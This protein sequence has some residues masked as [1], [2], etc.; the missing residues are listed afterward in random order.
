MA[1]ALAGTFL[2]SSPVL[3]GDKVLIGP[4]PDWL[5]PAPA[6][7]AQDLSAPGVA[8]PLYDSQT[9]I[10][11]DRVETYLDR[12]L[13]ISSPDML[14]RGGNLTFAWQ[15]DHG[16]LKVHAVSILRD[17]KVIDVLGDGTG[18]TI[19]RREERL[20]QAV[21]DGM[22]TAYLMVEGLRVGDTLRWSYSVTT[23]DPVLAGRA[24]M[25][26][27]LVASPATM[28]FGRVRLVWPAAREIAW[29]ALMPGIS[30]QPRAIA[31]GRREIS[32]ALPVAKLPEMP[33]DIPARF[34]PLP[35]IEAT[36]FAGW[37][38]VA[39]AMAPLFATEGT[40]PEGSDLARETDR[41]AAMG[42]DPVL[43][44]AE[45]LRVV[46]GEVRYQLVAL[47]TGNYEPQKPM[48]TWQKRYGDC[49]AKTMLLLAMLRRLGISAEPVLAN[50]RMGDLVPQRLPA[51]LAFDHVFVR[52]EVAGESFWLDGTS[53]GVRQADIRDVPPFGWVLPVRPSGSALVALPHRADARPSIDVDMA[54]DGS[55]SIHLP[56]PYTV[57]VR[58]TGPQVEQLREAGRAGDD[59]LEGMAER[60]A[61]SVTG[62]GLVDGARAE[63]D[64]VAGTWTLRFDGVGG[65]DFAWRD[66]QWRARLEPLLKLAF[67][68]DRSRSSWRTLPALTGDGGTSHVRWSIRLPE[69][70]R[71]FA[72]D[73]A[74]PLHLAP[75]AFS[76]DRTIT[77]AGQTV[78]DEET[79]AITGAEVA[80]ADIGSTRKAAADA[81]GRIA[82]IVLPAGYPQRWQEAERAARLPSIARVRAILDARIARKPDDAGRLA[83]RAWLAT[84]LFDWAA[85]EAD[86]TRALALDP[87]VQRY[88][89]RGQV[90]GQRGDNA[91]ALADAQ[92]AFDLDQDNAD[93]RD[94]LAGA[95]SEAGRNDDALALL[96]P[97]PD[98]A[99]EGGEGRVGTRAEILSRAGRNEELFGLLDGA[100][101]KRA[102]SP[103][104]LNARCWFRALA[105]VEL[106]GALSDCTRA[107]ELASDPA[108]YY[109]SRAMVHFRAGRLAEARADL[110]S[111][112]AIAPELA[113]TR[114]MR[115]IVAARLGDRRAAADELAAARRL[116]PVI[117]RFFARYGI[118]P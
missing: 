97:D 20:E 66:G 27:P 40:I 96:D 52:A 42:S 62:S 68:P 118:K 71:G 103:S 28:R 23:R 108:A 67:A 86:Y 12:A 51:P 90:R 14:N 59:A 44:M 81:A 109:D 102:S 60:Y 30:A 19:M 41:I 13:A 48:D 65:P 3:A 10:D 15:P 114:F 77:I 79:K 82:E 9:L 78:S 4:A 116:N 8:L 11:G 16:D 56:M 61:N 91:G 99:A 107:I 35:A 37:A 83:D 88:I 18:I 100:L 32:L 55:A 84:R 54:Y 87:A 1:F 50:S 2:S 112:L 26:Q 38:D 73:N 21:V 39:S 115:G 85:A 105:N 72:L 101:A 93:A 104:L 80:A 117:D 75:P 24:Q 98:P 57:T 63:Y 49:K 58:F 47:G 110:D 6:L 111:A 5:A 76:Y 74:D 94:F 89:D 43:R 33:D 7:S 106:D 113:A 36:N 95:L 25:V 17:G 64:A 45:A 53:L 29:K 31:G 34:Q 92:A 69:S 70:A 46:Q 22:L